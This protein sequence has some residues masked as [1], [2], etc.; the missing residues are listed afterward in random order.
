[1]TIPGIKEN[2]ER[3]SGFTAAS[4]AERSSISQLSDLK[5]PV[6]ILHGDKDENVPVSQAYLLRDELTRL[7]KQFEIKIFPGL[8]HGIGQQNVITY[9]TDFFKRKLR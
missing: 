8:A 9:A 3:E 1:V 7:K 4:I 2:M 6:L 5:C